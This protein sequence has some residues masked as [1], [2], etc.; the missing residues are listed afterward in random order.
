MK[1]ELI[2]GHALGF[3]S[4]CSKCLK[5]KTPQKGCSTTYHFILLMEEIRLTTWDANPVNNGINY[6]SL[7]W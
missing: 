4:R 2:L 7:N 1:W 3:Y 6:R 5:Q